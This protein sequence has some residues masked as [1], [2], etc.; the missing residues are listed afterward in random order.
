MSLI[1]CGIS[2]ILLDEDDEE[3]DELED[4][5]EDYDDDEPVPYNEFGKEKHF[6]PWHQ[7]F[8]LTMP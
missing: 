3:I 1:T 5:L 2:N 4:E 6:L 8:E 7:I